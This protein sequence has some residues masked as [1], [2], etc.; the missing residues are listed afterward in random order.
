MTSLCSG[1]VLSGHARTFLYRNLKDFYENMM[2]K[3][4]VH[5]KIK[6]TETESRERLYKSLTF[7]YP[8]D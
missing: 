3:S 2:L 7:N 1:D 8:M 4:V 5:M 6:I